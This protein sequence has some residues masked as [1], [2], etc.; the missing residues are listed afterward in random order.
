VLNAPDFGGRALNTRQRAPLCP[1]EA[2]ISQL[3]GVYGSD[4]ITFTDTF[5]VSEW[6]EWNHSPR[7]PDRLISHMVYCWNLISQKNTFLPL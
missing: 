7:A 2:P 5:V 6:N 4:T 1:S 3:A